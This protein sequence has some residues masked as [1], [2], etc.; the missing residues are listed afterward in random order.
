MLRKPIN[1]FVSTV[2]EAKD[3]EV[4]RAKSN[5]LTLRKEKRQGQVLNFVLTLLEASGNRLF[6]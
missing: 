4:L 5:R 3:H 1:E 6:D 2:K